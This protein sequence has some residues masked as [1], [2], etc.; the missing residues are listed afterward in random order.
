[1]APKIGSL[2]YA[3]DQGLGNL[4]KSFYDAGVLDEVK[5]IVHVSRPTHYEW[6]PKAEN[7]VHIQKLHLRHN[8]ASVQEFCKRMDVMLFFETPFDWSVIDYCRQVG[9]KTALMP[10]YECMPKQLPVF[11]DLYLNPSALD[12]QYFSSTEK[13]KSCFIPVPVEGKWLAG[14]RQRKQAKTFVHNSGHGGLRGRNGTAELVQ[15]LRHVQSSEVTI[16]IRTQT[17][18]IKIDFD[19]VYSGG[20]SGD[21]W[22]AS[23]RVGRCHVILQGGNMLPHKLYES[24]DV[25]LFPEKFNGLS[26][27]LQ[28]AYASGMLI[29]CLDRFPMNTWLPCAPLIPVERYQRSSISGR[30]LEFDEAIVNPVVIAEKI[31]EWYGYDISEHSIFARD[32]CQ[33]NLSWEVLKPRY[34]D[35]LEGLLR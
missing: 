34:M 13:T 5:I 10:M 33:K 9:V 31:D 6:Y 29:M 30:C 35:A 8:Q 3:T 23:G 16:I 12:A 25:F 26:L 21:Y 17:R 4:A 7:P 28:E 19:E 27:P 22:G 14:W 20:N 2:V 24:G 18:D 1:M 32:W 15:A 11:P